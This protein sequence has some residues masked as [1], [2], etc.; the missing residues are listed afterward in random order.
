MPLAKRKITPTAISRRPESWGVS[1]SGEEIILEGDY[2]L[3]AVS[4]ITLCGALQQLA[5][6]VLAAQDLAIDLEKQLTQISEKSKN[7][8]IRIA[9]LETRVINHNP[10]T[11][12]VRE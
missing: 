10:R 8:T 5:S 11:V 12:P 2:D 3:T 7:L 9:N 6:V 1:D 4:N